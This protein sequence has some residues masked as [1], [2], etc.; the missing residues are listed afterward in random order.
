MM[1]LDAAERVQ[2]AAA[3]PWSIGFSLFAAAAWTGFA[4]AYQVGED[5]AAGTLAMSAAAAANVAAAIAEL[6]TSDLYEL[7]AIDRWTQAGNLA[8]LSTAA[9]FGAG[10]D[11]CSRDCSFLLGA[12][13]VTLAAQALTF[14]VF[15]LVLPPLY[16]SRSYADY[17][18][19]APSQRP[20]FA[21]DFL[22]A[23]EARVRYAQ[24]GQ[25]TAFV[26]S[27]VLCIALAEQLDR[28]SSKQLMAGISIVAF[29]GAI[30]GFLQTTQTTPSE[31]LRAGELP[32][33]PVAF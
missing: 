31:R 18:R 30:A 24:Y 7:R 33:K 15:E 4:I 23:Q 28:G 1:H 27:G 26:L 21:L 17:R 13:S 25:S 6:N 9:A 19:L 29:I 8:M 10:G 32:P 12:V 14:A 20:Q 22:E 5:D 11:D 3:E 16:V 2:L